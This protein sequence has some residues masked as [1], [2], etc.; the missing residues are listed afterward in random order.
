MK[1]PAEIFGQLFIDFH[2]SGIVEDGKVISDAIPLFDPEFILSKYNELKNQVNFDLKEFFTSH[3]QIQKVLSSTFES[4]KNKN[5]LEHIENLWD[6]LTRKADK[7]IKGDSLIPLPNP[8]IVPGGRFNEIYYWDS[9]F[10]MLGLKVSGKADL[11][12]N[13]LDNFS[14]LICEIGFIP[15][16]NR[17]YFTSRSQ[18]PFFCLMVELLAE[19]KG[20]AVYSKYLINMEKEYEFWME[21]LNDVNLKTSK[22]VVFLEKGEYLNRYFDKDPSPRAEMYATDIEI[23]KASNRNEKEVFGDL[24]AACESGWDFSS[25]WLDDSEKLGS[26]QTSQII[27]L[28]LNCLLFLNEKIISKAYALKGEV[29]KSLIF[30]NK[31]EFRKSMIQ[32][33]L[34]DNDKGIYADWNIKTET[35]SNKIYA[36]LS[37]AL[38]SGIATEGESKTIS[39]MIENE[40]LGDGGIL[41]SNIISGQQ[42]D[43]PN[44]WAPLQWISIIGLRN[45]GYHELSEKIKDRWCTL[46]ERVY[47]DTGKLME[48]YNVADISKTSGGGE[49]PVQDGFG[50]TNGVLLALMSE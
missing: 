40:L 30:K 31:S 28:D 6:V 45:Y 44:G 48:K 12:E 25:R 23:A 14:Y 3:F 26:I 32:K 46:N 34:W 41:T 38:Y 50:W 21:G 1:G 5:V 19:L 35:F 4:D 2:V 24:K 39:E 8:Y 18:P 15:N 29:E 16:G 49:Y 33:Y 10:T 36:S 27:P 20:E 13:M 17:S 37:F 42:W 11:V 7:T 9:Y 22:H 43:G 47:K